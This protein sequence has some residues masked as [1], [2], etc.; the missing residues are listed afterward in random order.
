MKLNADIRLVRIK[1]FT[2]EHKDFIKFLRTAI[3]Q[4]VYDERADLKVLLFSNRIR[5]EIIKPLDA[6]IVEAITQAIQDDYPSVP[7]AI[8]KKVK[9]GLPDDMIYKNKQTRGSAKEKHRE[10]FWKNLKDEDLNQKARKTLKNWLK[11]F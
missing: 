8:E 9:S 1:T 4:L 11:I 10:E 2:Q 3:G 7:V 5:V 6:E